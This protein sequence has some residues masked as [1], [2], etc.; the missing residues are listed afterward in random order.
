[1]SEAH[2]MGSSFLSFVSAA[3]GAGLAVPAAGAGLE[4]VGTVLVTGGEPTV[5]I[6]GRRGTGGGDAI[7]KPGE[8]DAKS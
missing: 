3:L 8:V 1:M 4:T 2:T 7:C 6:S 5:P